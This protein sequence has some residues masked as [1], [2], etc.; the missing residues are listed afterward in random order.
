MRDTASHKR[1]KMWSET[2]RKIY[3]LDRQVFNKEIAGAE[4]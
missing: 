4:R 1:I 2:A 3:K